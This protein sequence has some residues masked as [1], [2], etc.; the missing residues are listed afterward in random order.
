MP[1]DWIKHVKKFARENNIAYA[2]AISDPRCKSSYWN[3]PGPMSKKTKDKYFK[4]LDRRMAE[5]MRED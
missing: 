2:C 3:S 1:N 5:I 4:E